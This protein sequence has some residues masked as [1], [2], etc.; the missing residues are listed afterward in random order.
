MTSI[1]I[2]NG[3][4]MLPDRMIEDG[5]VCC[6]ESVITYVGI[7][8]P[9]ADDV[10]LIDANGGFI[11]P[12]FID[13]HVHGGAGADFMDGTPEAVITA[14]AAHLR[15]GTTTIFPTT[16]TGSEQQIMEMIDACAQPLKQTFTQMSEGAPEHRR[17]P[18]LWSIF[19]GRQSWLP[20]RRRSAKSDRG[21][22][23]SDTSTPE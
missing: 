4:V 7:R 3:T 17:H 19:R 11:S 10:R 21:Q 18:S 5:M 14:C 12:G 15:H 20:F 2:I 23:F 9:V 1:A 6:D 8:K 16:T 13:L 22:N